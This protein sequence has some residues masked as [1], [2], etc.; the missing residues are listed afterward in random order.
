MTAYQ[1]WGWLCAAAVAAAVLCLVIG[2]M[3]RAGGTVGWLLTL[4]MQA[5]FALAVVAGLAQMAL[6]EYTESTRQ[7]LRREATHHPAPH[8]HSE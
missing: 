4:A 5:G 8:A 7:R 6:P 3:A 2:A 1:F